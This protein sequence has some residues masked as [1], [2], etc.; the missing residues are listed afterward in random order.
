[1]DG[2]SHGA[3]D[4]PARDARRDAFLKKHGIRTLRLSAEYVFQDMNGAVLTILDEL[5]R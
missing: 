2:E 1:V 4:N 5:G 3:G